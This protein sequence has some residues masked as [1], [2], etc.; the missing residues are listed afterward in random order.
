MTSYVSQLQDINPYVRY[1]HT[2]EVD[3][4]TPFPTVCPYDYRLMYISQGKGQVQIRDQVYT[5]SRG[6]LLLWQ[7][8]VPYGFLPPD[9]GSLTVIG[10]NFDFSSSHASLSIPLVPM[11]PRNFQKEN[12]IEVT[13][14]SDFPAFNEVVYLEHMQLAEEVLDK[15]LQEYAAQKM[16][17]SGKIRGY[18]LLLLFDMA[19]AL[20]S[21]PASRKEG[22]RQIDAII[23]YV[24]ENYNK[25]LT[26]VS[27]GEHFNFHPAYIS[28]LM[29]KHTGYPLHHYLIRYRIQEAFNLLQ[30]TSL[31]VT[32]IALRVGFSDTN[33][34]SRYFKKV[35][36]LRPRDCQAGGPL[37][38]E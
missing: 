8:G 4:S 16:L 9:E 11:P 27:V 2:F 10:I 15:I 36:G 26:N 33:Y 1:A 6:S 38:K 12:I 34:F 31:S 17:F 28:R 18:F 20:S 30:T 22:S 32:E 13:R 14:F 24:Q 5:V 19:R 37:R 35:Y 29:V 21:T 25:P 23:Q 3:R 7:P